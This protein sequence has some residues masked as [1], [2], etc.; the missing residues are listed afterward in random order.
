MVSGK[1]T[2]EVSCE[3]MGPVSPKKMKKNTLFGIPMHDAYH[4]EGKSV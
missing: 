4:F 2:L 3:F 1:P